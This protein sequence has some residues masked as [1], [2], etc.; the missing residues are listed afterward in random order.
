MN[1][2]VTAV[3][4]VGARIEPNSARTAYR[5]HSPGCEPCAGS[6]LHLFDIVHWNSCAHALPTTQQAETQTPQK[7]NLMAPNRGAKGGARTPRLPLL[8]EARL[9]L[10]AWSAIKQDM[11]EAWH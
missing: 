4:P 7:G 3:P 6:L 2:C 5:D 11:S 10:Q 9:N 8:G 1:W